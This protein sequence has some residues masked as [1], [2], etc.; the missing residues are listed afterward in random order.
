[1]D[2]SEIKAFEL[3]CRAYDSYYLDAHPSN[4]YLIAGV[5]V[6]V[7]ALVAILCVKREIYRVLTAVGWAACVVVILGLCAYESMRHND[8]RRSWITLR[9][10]ASVFATWGPTPGHDP[11][12]RQLTDQMLKWRM[13]YLK[14]SDTVDYEQFSHCELEIER[15]WANQH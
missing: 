13:E 12:L 1:M 9:Q 3:I 10:D 6:S 11:V 5:A 14:N 2:S 8:L 4:W 15:E 7:V